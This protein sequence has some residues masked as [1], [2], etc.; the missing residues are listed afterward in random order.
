MRLVRAE[1]MFGFSTGHCSTRGDYRDGNEDSLYA[2]RWSAFVADGVGGHAAGEVA[3][4]TVTIR[5]AAILDATEGRVDSEARLREIIAIAN[6][7]LR[8]RARH[9]SVLTGM[10]TT[11]TGIFSDGERIRIAHVGDSRAYCLRDGKLLQVTRD[12]SFVQDL[13]DAGEL[14]AE[15]A[16]SHPYRSVVI[17][18]LGGDAEDSAAVHILDE[19]PQVGDRW[20]LASDGLTDYVSENVVRQCL[21]SRASPQFVSELLV[22]TATALHARDNVTVVVADV[23]ALDGVPIYDPVFGGSAAADPASKRTL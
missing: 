6:A 9:D 5:I 21:A 7:D 15:A 3:S 16:K 14:T 12:D 8:L 1:P 22:G 4:A 2:S 10:A 11:F 18:V 17:N 23:I 19:I 20:L 13:L